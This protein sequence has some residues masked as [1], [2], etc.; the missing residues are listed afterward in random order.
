MDHNFTF[1]AD[2]YNFWSIYEALKTYYPIGIEKRVGGIYFEYPGITE[3]ERMVVDNIHAKGNYQSKWKQR[4]DDWSNELEQK[5]I[6]TTCGQEPS[7]SAYIELFHDE[8]NDRIFEKRLH[9]A[10]S[11]L[12]PFYTLFATDLTTLVE[13]DADSKKV[14]QRYQQTHRNVISPYN[15]YSELF[16]SLRRLIE[17][18]FKEYKF[19]PFM[20]H[21]AVI[22]GLQVRYR[23]ES[24]NRI[25]HGLFNQHFDFSSRI[26]GDQYEYGFD[27][28]LI[29][30]PNMGENW[31]IGPPGG[32]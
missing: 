6:G 30:N 15:G 22:K 8:A 12:G 9:F 10:V 25:Y 2:R 1:R 16:N 31:T 21:S 20:I 32:R 3:L 7:F 23:D 29:E 24:M 19:V 13:R 28:W 18:D 27:Q 14:S 4:I 11:L 17:R 26:I 5:I